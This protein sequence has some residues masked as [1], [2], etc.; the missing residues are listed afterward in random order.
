MV[1]AQLSCKVRHLQ[2]AFLPAVGSFPDLTESEVDEPGVASSSAGHADD[3]SRLHNHAHHMLWL[4]QGPLTW[5]DHS[6]ECPH[7]T[8]H[9]SIKGAQ[10]LQSLSMPLYLGSVPGNRR[11]RGHLEELALSGTL[12][13]AVLA[14]IGG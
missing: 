10:C 1:C 12:Q 7:E 3:V 11:L 14:L 6:R 13:G 4:A 8:E 2:V 9:P 5:S